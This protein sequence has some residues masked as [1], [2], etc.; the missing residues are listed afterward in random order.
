MSYRKLE[1]DNEYN[2]E[3]KRK[4]MP[5]PIKW[6]SPPTRLQRMKIH[7]NLHALKPLLKPHN[8]RVEGW[9][10]NIPVGQPKSRSTLIW[11]NWWLLTCKHPHKCNIHKISRRHS[12]GNL[13]KRK[14]GKILNISVSRMSLFQLM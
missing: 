3:L 5:R 7:K 8:K 1:A 12:W 4:Q 10:E 11:E 13:E 6:T 2:E 14:L 9:L